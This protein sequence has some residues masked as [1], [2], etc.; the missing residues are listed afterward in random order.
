MIEI[1]PNWHPIW[2]H[3]AI[4]LLLVSAGLFLLFGW[5]STWNGSQSQAL[6]VARW[7]LWLGVTAAAGALLTGY[8]A[9]G[10]VVHDDAGHANML[11]HRNWALIAAVFF[12]L[13]AILEYMKRKAPRASAFSI[14]L[15]VAGGAA[16]GI[17]GLKGAENVYE[18]GLGVQR[19]PQ[20]T[21]HEHSAHEHG[22]A[23]DK[24]QQSGGAQESADGHAHSHAAAES[25]APL[26][27]PEGAHESEDGH[28]HSHAAVESAASP[29]AGSIADADHPA[30]LVADRL[31]DAIANGDVETLR[32]LLAPDVLIFESGGVEA[33][34][35]EYEGH[36][37]PSDMAF[38]KAIEQE[39]ISREVFDE[40]DSAIVVT[41]SRVHGVYEEKAID[42][43]ST[44]T[45]VVKKVEHQWRVIHV[46][47]SSS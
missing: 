28:A 19:L 22:A 17:T 16:L 20:S 3:F 34:L 38:M 14:V 27:E 31:H 9:S 26:E 15:V 18:H 10:T 36:H 5:R 11:L 41:R 24:A 21:A 23:P 2:V 45:L 35:A 46:H 37:M 30:S 1:I 32:S 43:S 7:T 47:W 13:A 4:A 44:E 40:G 8:W 33:S 39:V 29:E 25:A 6:I 12:A 42:L